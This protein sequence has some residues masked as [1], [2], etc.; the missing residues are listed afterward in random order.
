[1]TSAAHAQHASAG[2]SCSGATL[3]LKP[4]GIERRDPA[5]KYIRERR[6]KAQSFPSQLETLRFR[7]SLFTIF[8][9]LRMSAFYAK[10]YQIN[11]IC[12]RNYN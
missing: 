5:V 8:F 7:S 6:T 9:E 12:Q 11:L 1:M 2:G 10:L 3:R 4:L